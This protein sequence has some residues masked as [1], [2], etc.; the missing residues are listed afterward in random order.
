MNDDV[1]EA[2]P[3]CPGVTQHQSVIAGITHTRH[4]DGRTNTVVMERLQSHTALISGHRAEDHRSGCYY[5][6]SFTQSRT[7]YIFFEFLLRD[8]CLHS[9]PGCGGAGKRRG[10]LWEEEAERSLVLR[11]WWRGAAERTEEQVKD[12]ELCVSVC[13]KIDRATVSE[14]WKLRNETDRKRD[15]RRGIKKISEGGVR[16]LCGWV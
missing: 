5:R 11:K 7:T 2:S 10:W 12:K 1:F 9:P 15:S 8:R 14:W 16:P 6:L 3:S 13:T 4:S